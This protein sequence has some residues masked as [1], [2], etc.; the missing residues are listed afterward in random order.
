MA[1]ISREPNGRRTIQFMATDGKRRSIRLGK[2]SQR[3]AEAIKVKIESLVAA[4]ITGYAL[5][6]ET[7]RWV[8]SLDG[9]MIAKLADAGLIR[10]REIALL[11]RFLDEY[12]DGRSDVKGSTRLVYGHTRRNLIDFFGREKPLREIQK[13][14]AD[15]WRVYLITKEGLADNTVRRRC[16]IAKQFFRAAVRKGLIAENPFSELTA[17]VRGNKA[18]ERFV[19]REVA[20][21]ILDACPDAQWRLLFALSRFGGLR[22]PSEHLNLR[23]TDVDWERSRFT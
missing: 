11:G 7:A 22:C 12:V 16:G 3:A 21:K 4:K 5:D 15:D 8:T 9:A 1:S 14:D 23:W 17:S 13:G 20:Q 19:S 2:V 6:D 10:R 18:R